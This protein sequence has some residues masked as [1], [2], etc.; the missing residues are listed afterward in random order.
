MFGGGSGGAG[1]AVLKMWDPGTVPGDCCRVSHT[2]NSVNF[3]PTTKL[4][5]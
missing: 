3:R 2:S 4:F 5:T 1:E